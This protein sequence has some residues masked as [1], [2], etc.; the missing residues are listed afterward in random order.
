MKIFLK[1]QD[2]LIILNICYEGLPYP[3]LSRW[4]EKDLCLKDKILGIKDKFFL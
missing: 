1:N 4:N 3:Y 2:F